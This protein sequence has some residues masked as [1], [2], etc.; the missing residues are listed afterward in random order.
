M[1]DGWSGRTRRRR[2]RAGRV[3]HGGSGATV[4]CSGSGKAELRRAAAA[5]VAVAQDVAVQ[6][7]RRHP[8]GA[9]PGHARADPI[10]PG[11]GRTG[12]GAASR[13]RSGAPWPASARR[14]AAGGAP[15]AAPA[16][17]AG[18]R[19]CSTGSWRSPATRQ[20]GRP[21]GSVHSR[22]SRVLGTKVASAMNTIGASSPLAPW[23]VST[24]TS[25]RGWSGSRIS[26]VVS[27]RSQ[28]RNACIEG[29]WLCSN[30]SAWARKAS[31]GS[32]A[33][34]PRRASRRLRPPPSPRSRA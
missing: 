4:A 28:C 11:R 14:R 24:R 30:A 17:R 29:G 2:R 1:R 8:L 3:S 16:R 25:S 34:G 32:F 10:V 12:S 20:S 19:P 6:G 33:A 26:S 9:E 22:R 23:Q 31:I 5:T 18:R 21:S 27:A 15:A 13:P 7:R